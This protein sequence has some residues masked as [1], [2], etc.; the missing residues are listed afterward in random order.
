MRTGSAVEEGTADSNGNS[1][2]TGADAPVSE[3]DMVVN[4][5]QWESGLN[6]R[7]EHR[8]RQW[9]RKKRPQHRLKIICRKGRELLLIKG[10]AHSVQHQ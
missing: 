6:V 10:K 4:E 2:C 9:K 1:S 3:S 5:I 8:E 7:R